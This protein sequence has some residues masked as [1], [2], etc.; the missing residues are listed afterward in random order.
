MLKC[1]IQRK[2]FWWKEFQRWNYLV[3][4]K[5][6]YQSKRKSVKLDEIKVTVYLSAFLCSKQIQKSHGLR[7]AHF[8]SWISRLVMFQAVSWTWVFSI[9]FMLRIWS[10]AT[11]N[12]FFFPCRL[13][14]KC[15]AYFGSLFVSSIKS[16][17]VKANHMTKAKISEGRK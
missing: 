17:M 9:C 7:Y 8:P 4:L 16:S 14:H 13:K 3:S 10:K 5:W 11:K 2:E 15:S 12:F 1:L 6:Q